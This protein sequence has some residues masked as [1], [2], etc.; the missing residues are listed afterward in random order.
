MLNPSSA[1]LRL[2]I[3][4]AL[5][6]CLAM[7]LAQLLRLPQGYWA[8]ITAMIVMQAN[9]GAAVRQSWVR[10]AATAVGAAVSIPFVTF[11][12]QNLGAF[13]VAVFV[14]VVLCTI[15]H[16]D[17]GLRLA[18][19]TIAII[20][21]IPHA[22]HAWVP[23]VD[24]FLEVSFG[25][26][27][28][29]LVAEFVWPSSA[30]EDLRR[31]LAAALLQLDAFV[32]ALLQRFRG[33]NGGDLDELRERLATQTRQNADSQAHGRYEPT[34]W[35]ASGK[36]LAK[37]L[38]HEERLSQAAATLDIAC[39]GPFCGGVD[40]KWDPEFSALCV[41]ISAALQRIA[42]GISARKV[43]TPEFDFAAAIHT[44]DAKANPESI[45]GALAAPGA[46]SLEGV[47]RSHTLYFA[48]EALARELAAAQ[49][50][51]RELSTKGSTQTNAT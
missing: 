20:M 7:Y 16:L 44:L 43:S 39:G 38:Q 21:L 23:A 31:G 28:A 45:S 25:I 1:N 37:L 13:G 19:V 30:Q 50:T 9:L 34:R 32:A 27:I 33:E 49:L 35:S 15:L 47:L 40:P 22:G 3:K 29:L 42:A 18:A 4:T 46:R 14:T 41:G 12:G 48:L 2:A 26:L 5:A 36:T 10:F 51:A 6:G 11:F 24:R 17:E 8:A